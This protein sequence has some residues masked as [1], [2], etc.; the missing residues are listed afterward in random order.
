MDANVATTEVR[1]IQVY[2]HK[3]IKCTHIIQYNKSEV[4]CK[5]KDEIRFMK[6]DKFSLERLSC[7]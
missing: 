1:Y 7:N 4:K 2:L 3:D 6:V 5:S